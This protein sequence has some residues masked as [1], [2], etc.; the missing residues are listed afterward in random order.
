M[1]G[2]ATS[3][4]ANVIPERWRTQALLGK[5]TTYPGSSKHLTHKNRSRI[6]TLIYQG[7][8]LDSGN[9]RDDVFCKDHP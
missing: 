6:I 4:I 8:A 7:S 9:F 5:Q 1:W 3:L 2:D